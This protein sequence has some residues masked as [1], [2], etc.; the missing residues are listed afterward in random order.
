MKS[1][2][3]KNHKHGKKDIQFPETITVGELIEKL[4]KVDPDLPV[5]TH[6]GDC[7]AIPVNHSHK[8]RVYHFGEHW[9]SGGGESFMEDH[10]ECKEE[11][12]N[13]FLIG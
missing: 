13:A 4:M 10:L 12:K 2:T 5:V 1:L 8:T 11:E 6:D 9:S 7:F 3:L